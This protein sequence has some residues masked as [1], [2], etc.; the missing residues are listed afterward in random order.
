MSETATKSTDS[1]MSKDLAA[2][3]E[4]GIEQVTAEMKVERSDTSTAISGEK[5]EKNVETDEGNIPSEEDHSDELEED[6]SSDSGEESSNDT[7]DDDDNDAVTDELIER[8]VKSDYFSMAEAK[9]F[10]SATLLEKMCDKLDAQAGKTDEGNGSTESVGEPDI[11]ANIPEIEL[12]PDVEYDESVIGLVESVKAL[13]DFVKSQ[14]EQIKDLKAAGEASEARSLF[15]S[16]ISEMDKDYAKA[17]KD[18]PEKRDELRKEFDALSAGYKATGKEV[19]PDDIFK[20]AVAVVLG[21]VKISI[22]EKKLGKREKGQ[23]NRPGNSK[24]KNTANPMDEL[25][26][27]IDKKFFK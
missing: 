22:T 18:E 1:K 17:L 10:A 19:S 16:K 8:A 12:D 24:N 3:I 25:A 9:A 4:A 27:S 15:E 13:K 26:D 2:E 6:E 21:D 14:S 5:D 7:D 11:L 20:K 23:I